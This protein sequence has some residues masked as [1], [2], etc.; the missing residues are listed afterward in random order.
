[1]QLLENLKSTSYYSMSYRYKFQDNPESESNHSAMGWIR[2]VF[3]EGGD[4]ADEWAAVSPPR[5]KVP[6]YRWSLGPLLL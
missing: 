2:K 1:M 6:F 5:G 4:V 3:L